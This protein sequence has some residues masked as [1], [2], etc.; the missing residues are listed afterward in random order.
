MAG[1][2]ETEAWRLSSGLALASDSARAVFFP[3]LADG[4]VHMGA[5]PLLISYIL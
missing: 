1:G 2:Q 3:L 5:F 4:T